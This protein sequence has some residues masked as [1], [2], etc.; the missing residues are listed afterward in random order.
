MS[1]NG[2]KCSIIFQIRRWG[3]V[4]HVFVA[5][6]RTINSALDQS[7]EYDVDS[8]RLCKQTPIPEPLLIK[9]NFNQDV[10]HTGGLMF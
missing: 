3:D 8:L 9:P 6:N 7:P 4:L 1:E 5:L 2:E 10:L